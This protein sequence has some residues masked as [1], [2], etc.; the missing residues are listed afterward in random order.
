MKEQ[1]TVYCEAP[2]CENNADTANDL[3]YV[4]RGWIRLIESL[5]SGGGI[6]EVRCCSWDCVLKLA[7]TVPPMEI[8]G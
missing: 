3:P 5:P 8:I 2:D 6:D 4:P 7:A 1:R